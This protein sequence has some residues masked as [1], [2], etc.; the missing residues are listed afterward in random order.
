[1]TTQQVPRL[2]AADPWDRQQGIKAVAEFQVECL[3]TPLGREWA[4]V[5]PTIQLDD[6]VYDLLKPAQIKTFPAAPA[7]RDLLCVA[8]MKRA[9]TA[10]GVALLNLAEQN[11]GHITHADG[12]WT[13]RWWATVGSRLTVAVVRLDGNLKGQARVVPVE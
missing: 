4:W 3:F 6:G 8:W 2:P 9:I 13:G 5:R 12:S 7:S 1:M 10:G 11:P